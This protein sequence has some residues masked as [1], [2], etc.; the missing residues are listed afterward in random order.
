MIIFVFI[1]GNIYYV[2]F[3]GNGVTPAIT[4]IE[5]FHRRARELCSEKGYNDYRAYDEQDLNSERASA[6]NLPGF[7]N[8]AIGQKFI[9][10]EHAGYVEFLHKN[11]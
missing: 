2:S 8:L 7:T 10:P 11:Q 1:K 5:Y 4:T 3:H 6:H 9:Y